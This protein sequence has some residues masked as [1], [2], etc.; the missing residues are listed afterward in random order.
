MKKFISILLIFI[1]VFSSTISFANSKDQYKNMKIKDLDPSSWYYNS[2]MKMIEYN[3][4]TG[5]EDD[6]FRPN[7]FVKRSEYAA[8]LVRSLKIPIDQ[9]P[10]SSFVDLRNSDWETKYV[11]AAK[12]YL[13]G[14]KSANGNL[15]KSTSFTL[16]EDIMVALVKALDYDIYETDLDILD[17][18]EDSNLISK[19]LRSYVATAIE[20]GL[21]S[22]YEIHGK[23]YIKPMQKITR[24]ETAKLLFSVIEDE[25]ITFDEDE[26]IILDDTDYNEDLSL[27]VK[28]NKEGNGFDL[29]WDEYDG[30]NLRY[31]KVVASST[32]DNP[33]YPENGYY[34][35]FTN[36]E[37]TKCTIL[38]GE[39]YHKDSIAAFEKGTV[40]NFRI[41]VVK[42]DGSARTFTNTVSLG[43][44]TVEDETF[45]LSGTIN[46]DNDEFILEWDKYEENNFE[47]FKVVASSEGNNPTY[48]EDYYTEYTSNDDDNSIA[49]PVGSTFNNENATETFEPNKEY[50][51]KIVVIKNDGSEKTYSNNIKLEIVEDNEINLTGEIVDNEFNLNWN[52]YIA[53]DF[54]GYKVVASIGDETPTYPENGYY[55]YITSS[56]S[57]S[58]TIN[59]GDSYNGNEIS[60]FVA[61]QNYHFAITV[62][63]NNGNDKTYS[64]TVDLEIEEETVIPGNE[65]T[66]TGEIINNKFNL[67]WNKYLGSDFQGYKVVASIADNTPTYSENGYYQYI[68]DSDLNSAT[69]DLGDSYNGDEILSFIVNQNYHFAITVLKNNGNDKIYSNTTDLE[70]TE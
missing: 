56:D 41:T 69:I 36:P 39:G 38:L 30:G 32:V 40:Y 55:Q 58:A 67:Q 27:E 20:H 5:Y 11:E 54:A 15:F 46:D 24:A 48:P 33:T 62:L 34:K 37:D 8:L 47:K 19:N 14:Y 63:K 1:L 53:S 35:Y 65:I 51:F 45:D 31:Y 16:R 2:V 42:N 43:I 3:I 57:N 60:N 44:P 64:N 4:I 49:I 25:K 52:E 66:L 68:T 22:G 70:I 28:I 12:S 29:E 9:H 21:I 50:N 7:N 59:L 61:N 6:T 18:Y 17:E 23:K 26:K 10:I 13:T